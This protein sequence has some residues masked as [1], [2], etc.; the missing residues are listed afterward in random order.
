MLPSMRILNVHFGD[1]LFPIEQPGE[2]GDEYPMS[3]GIFDAQAK[4]LE[5]VRMRRQTFP[6]ELFSVYSFL[7]LRQLEVK[8]C[9]DHE[10]IPSTAVA[11]GLLTTFMKEGVFIHPKLDFFELNEGRFE[12]SVHPFGVPTVKKI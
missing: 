2:D 12:I 4:Q 8:G 7:E 11:E 1:S 9:T 3:Q 10:E 6:T 5:I